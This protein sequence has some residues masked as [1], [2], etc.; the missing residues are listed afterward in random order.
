M[1]DRAGTNSKI[2]LG[3][4]VVSEFTQMDRRAMLQRAIL[5]V[6]GSTIAAAGGGRAAAEPAASSAR[7]TPVQFNLCSAVAGTIVPKTDTPGAVEVGVP[8]LFDGLL[9]NWASP[10]HRAVIVGALEAIDTAAREKTPKGFAAL[11][12]DERFAFLKA[13]DAAALKPVP[14]TGDKPAPSSAIGDPSVADPGYAK[15]K[16]LLVILYYYSEPAETEEFAYVHAP[17]KWQ[18]SIP[19]T[20]DTRPAGGVSPF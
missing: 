13:Y 2:K 9:R 11:S 1:A 8:K 5:L 10:Q 3:E 19:V 15:L 16:E 12:P 18:P 20:S 17:G 14:R 7:L 6:A 4:W